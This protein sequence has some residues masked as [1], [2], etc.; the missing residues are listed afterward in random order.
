M[1]DF[2]SEFAGFTDFGNVVTVT[3]LSVSLIL[4]FV[5]AV[6]AAK[7][8]QIGRSDLS[9]YNDFPH[10]L[11]LSSMIAAGITTIIGSS[12]VMAVILVA[13]ISLLRFRQE[14]KDI[15]DASFLFLVIST[16]IA[17][18]AG[19]Y[20]A[21]TTLTLIVCLASLLLHFFKFGRTY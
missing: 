15:R 12:L 9:S 19:L 1:N 16:G 4:S 18:G 21:A 6:F 13:A 8:W 14:S 2:V 3:Q 10:T 17:S 20:V 11:V 7:T 5:L